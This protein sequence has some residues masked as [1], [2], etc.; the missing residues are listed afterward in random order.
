MCPK[1]SRISNNLS[2]DDVSRDLQKYKDLAIKYGATD[3]KIIKS[4]QII[5]DDR[6]RMKCLHP[7]CKGYGTN[8]HCPPYVGN[9]DETRRLISL[10]KYALFIMMKVPSNELVG[11]NVEEEKRQMISSRKLNEIVSRI[12]S[13]AFY[14]GHHLA[15]GFSTGCKSLWC[16]DEECSALITG[17][18]CRH[19]LKARAGMDAVGMDVYTMVAKVGWEIYPIGK[20]ANP[21]DVPH[22]LR[23]GLVLIR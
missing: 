18:S 17:Q 19:P 5:V 14:D 11:P 16:P 8:I 15:T 10:Y 23:L 21:K 12:E 20:E 3:A 2:D 1:I 9:L 4:S 22:G 7:V 13:A 6:V